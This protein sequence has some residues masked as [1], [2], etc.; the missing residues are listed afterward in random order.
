MLLLQRFREEPQLSLLLSHGCSVSGAEMRADSEC[1]Q[2]MNGTVQWGHPKPCHLAINANGINLFVHVA[3]L[4]EL[5]L[6]GA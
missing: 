6:V 4:N 2:Y 3:N 1:R 5:L